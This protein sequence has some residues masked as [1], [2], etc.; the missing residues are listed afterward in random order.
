M[1]AYTVT[2]LRFHAQGT[3]YFSDISLDNINV[4]KNKSTYA[5]TTDAS[6]GT[7]GW[8]ATDTEDITVT[9]SADATYAG[10]YTLTVT[11]INGC[12]NSDITVVNAQNQWTGAVSTAWTN[13]GNWSNGTVPLS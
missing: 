6:N 3:S 10:N 2:K 12:Q 8:S 5:W 1:S 9:A 13:T 11:D 4:I 7:T